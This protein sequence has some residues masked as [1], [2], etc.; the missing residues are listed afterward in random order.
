MKYLIFALFTLSGFFIVP[1]PSLQPVQIDTAVL[2]T[3][4]AAQAVQLYCLETDL[5]CI[6]DHLKTVERKIDK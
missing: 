2:D 4:M 3:T 1:E 5:D 6:S